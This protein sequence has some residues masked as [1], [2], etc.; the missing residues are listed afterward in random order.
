V[1]TW[2]K[3]KRLETVMTATSMKAKMSAEMFDGGTPK[4]SQE[5]KTKRVATHSSG[6][7]PDRNDRLNF[8]HRGRS[9]GGEEEL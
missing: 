6:A 9:S 4:G 3:E 2:K 5:S 7:N 8:I 1:H